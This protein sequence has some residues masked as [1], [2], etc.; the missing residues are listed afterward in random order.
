MKVAGIDYIEN[1]SGEPVVF[2]HGI[3]GGANSFDTQLHELNQYQCIAWNMPGY[4]ASEAAV[5]PPSFSSLSDVLSQFINELKFT[6]VHLVGQ[7]IGGMLALEHAIVKP[8]QVA[9]LT[10]IAS[11]PSFGGADESF[12]HKFLKARLAPLEGAIRGR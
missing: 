8:E 2:L 1:G 9:S 4:G 3:G 10:I 12:K 11:T 7:S 6:K 5:W